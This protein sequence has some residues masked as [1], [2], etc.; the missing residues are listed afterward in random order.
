MTKKYR[1]S[2][3]IVLGGQVWI[4]DSFVGHFEGCI[5]GQIGISAPFGG[6]PPAGPEVGSPLSF[7][8]VEKVTL[9]EF[10]LIAFAEKFVVP[11]GIQFG[12]VTAHDIDEACR[13]FVFLK[14]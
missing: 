11:V 1:G 13:Y 6:K 12:V 9:G 10:G 3:L 2:G 7:V 4:L 14:W 8:V 5:K